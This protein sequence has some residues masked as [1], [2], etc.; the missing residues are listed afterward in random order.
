MRECVWLH[1]QG[2]AS[3]R[4]K[5]PRAASTIQDPGDRSSTSV[6]TRS[7]PKMDSCRR[8]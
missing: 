3:G 1:L 2:Y 8:V 7:P 4:V 6:S 5:D